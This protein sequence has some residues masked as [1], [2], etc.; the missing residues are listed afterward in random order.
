M[1]RPRLPIVT[2]TTDFGLTDS[3][4]AEMKGVL[5][6]ACPEVRIVDVTHGVPPQDVLAGGF[7]VERALRAFPPGTVHVAVVDPGVGSDRRI[8]SVDLHDQH[9]LCPDNGL[10][11]WAWRRLAGGVAHELTWRPPQSSATFH[12]RDIFAPAAAKLVAE[13]S[14]APRLSGPAVEPILLPVTPATDRPAEAEVIHVD[15]FGNVTT[16]VPVEA[17]ASPA[18]RG[19]RVARRS[20][21]PV[22]R[23]YADVAD[24]E[25]LALIGSSGL[26][27]IAVRN[28]NAAH[29]LGLR[30]GDRL[31]IDY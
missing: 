24:G 31:T 7:A 10:I 19:I 9:V 3:Y 11:T 27:E 18:P 22:R 30:V 29:T 14:S 13:P 15:H 26:L 8:L 16:N 25:P 4:V 21:G 12:G 20:L 28:G 17:I 2:L 5:L 6:A 1:P 23:T